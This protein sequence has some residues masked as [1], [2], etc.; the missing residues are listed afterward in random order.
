MRDVF[1][2]NLMSKDVKVM[3]FLCPMVMC[4]SRACC[5]L[6]ETHSCILVWGAELLGTVVHRKALVILPW[7]A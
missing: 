7:G 6:S 5:V 2:G 1:S 3:R 4:T